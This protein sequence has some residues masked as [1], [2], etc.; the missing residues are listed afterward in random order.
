MVA[1]SIAGKRNAEAQRQRDYCDLCE[2]FDQHDT[3][4]CPR[5][6]T[7]ETER[8]SHNT[9]FSPSSAT[10]RGGVARQK[11][12]GG[13]YESRL[14]CDICDAFDLHD[15]RQCPKLSPATNTAVGGNSINRT[16]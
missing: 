12:G 8:L 6:E 14:L 4:A 5:R 2:V 15:T 11:G 9:S 10:Q 3:A 7:E 13:A 1:E 16:S